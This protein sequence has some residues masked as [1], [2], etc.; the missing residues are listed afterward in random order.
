MKGKYL[1]IDKSVLPEVFEKV[2]I[3]KELIRLGK[4]AG[5]TQAVRE[6]GI[7][8][9]TFYKYKDHVFSMYDNRR[10]KMISI[11]F[12]LSHETGLLSKVLNEI[13]NNRGN[14]LTINQGIP[15]NNVA[16]I[17]ITFDISN[18]DREISQVLYDIENI[19][20][21]EKFTLMSME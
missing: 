8:R 15:I 16:N 21:V 10:G 3:A 14:I 20:G 5:I 17:S 7:S 9:S 4:V 18:M 19:A 6:V 11:S 2:L 1:I 13:S 12:L